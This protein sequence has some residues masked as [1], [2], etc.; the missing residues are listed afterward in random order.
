[1]RRLSYRNEFHY[2]QRRCSRC[3]KAVVSVH[4]EEQRY[5]IY[6][7]KCW[8]GDGWNALSYG[9]EFDPRRGFLEQFFELRDAV[10]QVAMMNDNGVTSENCEYTQDFA[11]GKNCYLVTASWQQQDCM[12]STQCNHVKDVL[13]SFVIAL[14]CEL[15]YQ[16]L[17]G[18]HLYSCTYLDHCSNCKDCHFGFDLRG[19]S[20]CLCC[21]GLRQKR[22]YI[23]NQEYS[24][25]AYRKK[26]A[27]Y[28]CDS[29]SGTNNTLREF[30]KFLEKFPRRAVYQT[31][32][33]QC[34][35]D[36]LFNCRNFHG[37]GFINGEHCRYCW[38][39]DG[40]INCYDVTNTGKPQWC[41]EGVTPDNSYMTHF[42]TWCWRDKYTYYSDNCHSSENLLGCIALRRQKFCI[43]NKQYSR[44]DYE[45]LAARI[46][47]Q[48]QQS[49][50]WGEF[51]PLANAPFAYNISRAADLY[52]LTQE[53]ALATGL[54][55]K[56]PDHKQYAPPDYMIPDSINDITDT[57]LHHLLACHTCGRNYR[58]LKQELDFYRKLLLPI[59][60]ECPDCRRKDRESSYPLSGQ[61][62][63]R[64][65][66]QCRNEVLTVY[67]PEEKSEVL[68]EQCYLKEVY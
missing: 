6:C 50:Q 40:P 66:A 43:L 11:Y 67:R 18:Q 61:L 42:T 28:N 68:C 10:P 60:R 20:D 31:N 36:S 29:W 30:R 44:E 56:Q 17:H 8:W 15:V 59:P 49:G 37:T 27:E 46:L 1:M 4:P 45:R 54:S 16:C 55:W 57:I 19:C 5:P 52:P 25:E 63:P 38:M 22:F 2:Y 12:Y 35:G 58:I 62:F 51:F 41:Y 21:A 47:R 39:G 23:F 32:C 9:K 13:D 53:Q 34:E 14:D 33:D 64:A 24:E 7:H 26:V 48:L 65:C 3:T